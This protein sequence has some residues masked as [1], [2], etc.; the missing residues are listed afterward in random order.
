MIR[1]KKT[2]THP[3]IY[4]SKKIELP[5]VIPNRIHRAN[6]EF[7][8][9]DHFGISYEGRVFLNNPKATYTTTKTPKNG[10]VGSFHIFGHGGVCLGGKGHCT[11]PS[12]KQGAY[13]LRR[14]HMMHPIFKSVKITEPL[15][16]IIKT[17]KD[18]VV[19]V[20]P[21]L[22]GEDDTGMKS[23]FRFKKMTLVTYDK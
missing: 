10:Y 20:V 15:K 13:D 22:M 16:K 17:R 21:I 9:I 7:Y 4:V 14:E 6:L 23:I 5:T 11:P 18:I 1:T 2:I 19:T 8:D 3:E 12:K